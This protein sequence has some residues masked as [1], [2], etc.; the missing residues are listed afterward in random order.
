MIFG[1]GCDIC[2][3]ERFAQMA[4]RHPGAVAKILTEAEASLAIQSQAGRF[5]AKEAL[6]KA[7]GKRPDLVSKL[8]WQEVAVVNDDS[9]MPSFNFTGQSLNA[10]TAFGITDIHLSISH[11]AG[12]AMAMVIV[13]QLPGRSAS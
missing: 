6:I 2:S 11:D 10:L 3:I 1:I 8:S 4:A 13:E 9:G 5:A 7:L 12:V